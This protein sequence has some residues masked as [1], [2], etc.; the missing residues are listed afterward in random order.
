MDP[1][2]V[3]FGVGAPNTESRYVILLRYY[4]LTVQYVSCIKVLYI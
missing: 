1:K 3:L 2:F 4:K